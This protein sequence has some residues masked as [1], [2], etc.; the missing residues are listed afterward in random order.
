MPPT[1]PLA[2]QSMLEVLTN[3][4]TAWVIIP[5]LIFGTFM[6]KSIVSPITARVKMLER[7]K[8]RQMYEKLAMEKLDVIK[9]AVAMGYKQNELAELDEQL[10]KVIGSDAMQRVL[11]GKSLKSMDIQR[12]AI[13]IDVNTGEKRKTLDIG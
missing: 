6:L 3:P 8:L 5:M 2:L 4:A 1:L 13:T 12:P 10:E 11:E 9:T 7:D